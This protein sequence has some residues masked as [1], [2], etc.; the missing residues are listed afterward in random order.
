LAE[1]GGGEGETSTFQS[2]NIRLFLMQ[3]HRD[4]TGYMQ[5]SDVC[6]FHVSVSFQ[7]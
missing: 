1:A 3:A 2:I 7:V 4:A 6:E 5:H